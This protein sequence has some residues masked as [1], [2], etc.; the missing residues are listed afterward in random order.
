MFGILEYVG[1]VVE[2]DIFGVD[3]CID[4]W[5]ELFVGVVEGELIGNIE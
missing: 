4:D 5:V 1:W 3:F 2:V